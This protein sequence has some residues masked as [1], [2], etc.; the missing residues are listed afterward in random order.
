MN[1]K[2]LENEIKLAFAT[3]DF[4][5]LL[6]VSMQFPSEKFAEAVR[7]GS[8]W[9]D[10]IA[11]L[12]DIS[13]NDEDIHL[14]DTNIK[15]LRASKETPEL[16]TE[17]RCEYTRLFND[18]KRPQLAIYESVFSYSPEGNKQKPML[19]MSPEAMDAEKCYSHAGIKVE[20]KFGEPA[21]HMA[22]ELEFMMFLYANK[23]KALRENNLTNLEITNHHIRKFKESHLEKWGYKFFDC[24]EEA[25]TLD[26][27]ALIA[28]LA[29]VG[30]KRVLDL[31]V[32]VLSK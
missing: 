23:G 26:H 9:E 12:E 5:Q 13:C 15:S 10:A 30:L 27:Y 21:D 16:M 29:K 24:L 8:Y 32:A 28:R 6:S 31:E 4:Y 19:F 2:S 17:L 25:T 22:A 3:S 7:Q 1:S 11:I 20:K 14:V 18:P